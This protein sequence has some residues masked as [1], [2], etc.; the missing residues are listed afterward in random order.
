MTN[1]N[2]AFEDFSLEGWIFTSKLERK[3]NKVQEKGNYKPSLELLQEF[4][5][6]AYKH[7]KRLVKIAVWKTRKAKFKRYSENIIN[8]FGKN[9][10]EKY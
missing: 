3:L 5:P 10:K 1:I 6:T 9:E 7:L 2:L 4:N 8:Y